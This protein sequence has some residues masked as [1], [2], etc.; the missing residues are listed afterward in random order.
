MATHLRDVKKIR[1]DTAQNLLDLYREARTAGLKD[2]YA[3][4]WAIRVAESNRQ[5][6]VWRPPKNP[7]N[8]RGCTFYSDNDPNAQTDTFDR[9]V[10]SAI[11]TS[12]LKPYD[13]PTISV[14]NMV[15]KCLK[16]YRPDVYSNFKKAHDNYANIIRRKIP[17]STFLDNS[18]LM[19]WAHI[20]RGRD[21][22]IK[23][24][25][26]FDINSAVD[27][28]LKNGNLT[29]YVH[30]VQAV[31]YGIANTSFFRHIRSYRFM[32][33]YAVKNIAWIRNHRGEVDE[34]ISYGAIELIKRDPTI[35]PD[36]IVALNSRPKRERPVG[37]FP[38]SVTELPNTGTT[39][40]E[41]RPLRSEYECK[42][43]ARTL[44]NCAAGYPARI[45]AGS[46]VLIGLFLTDNPDSVIAL[47]EIASE[48]K[49]PI[50]N[51]VLGVHNNRLLPEVE[52]SFNEY[53]LQLIKLKTS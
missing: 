8:A 21:L 4:K 49:A 6:S 2:K 25:G 33:K 30:K 39:Y 29:L 35:H 47:G 32:K 52:R 53:P 44:G 17:I 15:L 36:R 45:V 9:L 5:G 11:G 14:D 10:R 43:V 7:K 37:P 48:G 34:L 46:C 20:N 16:K 41:L 28:I 19:D 40:G 12:N 1:L 27:I 13:M 31:G 42:L 18:Y 3:K 26:T 24:F 23:G 38:K 51:Q 22:F 50:W